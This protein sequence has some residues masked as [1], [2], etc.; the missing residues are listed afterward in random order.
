M[1]NNTRANET[2]NVLSLLKYTNSY[3]DT[4]GKD[5][6]FYLDTSTVITE[7]RPAQGLYNAGFARRKLLTDAA[8]VNKISIL[9]NLYSYFAAFKNQLHP[10]IKTKIILKLEN[11]NN[12]I[13]RKQ[14]A[15]DSK[16]IITKLRLWCPKIIFNGKGM[17]EYLENYLKTKKWTYLR[18]HQDIDQ[19]A[20]VNS[21]FCISTGI[22]RP[23]HVFVWVVPTA[24]YNNQQQNI[25]IFKTFN[26]GAN[27]RYFSKAQLEINNS[28]YYPQ[29][30]MTSDEESKLYRALMSYN[31]AYN[32][33]LKGR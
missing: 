6:F 5:Q 9:L 13:F 26:I 29:L 27:H 7:S 16:V 24:A 4:V 33:F 22:R 14:A 25:F 30:D 2:L 12:V 15:P 1:Y 23:R 20:A 18:E 17:K 28:V 31:S 21:Y 3:A 11:D 10:K 8:A 32:D 19:T